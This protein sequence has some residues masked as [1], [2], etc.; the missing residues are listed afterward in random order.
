MY[1]SGYPRCCGIAIIE[2][3]GGSGEWWDSD[4]NR[5]LEEF[6]K[7]FALAS[8]IDNQYAMIL[9]ALNTRQLKFYGETLENLGFKEL[10]K[11]SNP[12]SGRNIYL[13][14]W[15]KPTRS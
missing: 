12:K 3:I 5:S 15:T 7:T 9:V 2:E 14:C 10:N 1:Y 6:E 8:H 11:R 4:D 13:Y